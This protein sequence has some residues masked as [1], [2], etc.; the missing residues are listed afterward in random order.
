MTLR[1]KIVQTVDGS[2]SIKPNVTREAVV[3]MIRP[4]KLSFAFTRRVSMPLLIRICCG[5]YKSKRLEK[6]FYYR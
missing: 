5:H 6:P 2:V 4:K 1:P 3:G